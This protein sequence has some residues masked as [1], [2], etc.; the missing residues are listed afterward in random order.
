REEWHCHPQLKTLVIKPTLIGS[1]SDCE[2]LVQRARTGNLRVVV[3]SS[4]ESDLGLGLLARLA[5]EWAPKEPPGL[6]TGHWLTERLTT[7]TGEVM[8]ENVHCL[9]K[10]ENSA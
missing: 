9:S 5:G 10:M 3:S 8:T 6:D 4:F 7:T 1:L 2:A